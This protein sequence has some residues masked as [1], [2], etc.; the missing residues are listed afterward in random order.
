MGEVALRRITGEGYFCMYGMALRSVG[1]ENKN[2]TVLSTSDRQRL[3]CF[4][5]RRASETRLID[6]KVN[7]NKALGINA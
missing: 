4:Q 6:D 2:K 3:D 7:V 1:R 5:S